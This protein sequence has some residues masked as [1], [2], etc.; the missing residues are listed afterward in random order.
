MSTKNVDAQRRRIIAGNWKMNGNLQTNWDLLDKIAEYRDS[1]EEL[2][3]E[4]SDP[5]ECMS[6]CI[7]FP[8]AVYIHQTS[9][10]LEDSP[11]QW[12]AQNVSQ[13]ADGAY[14]GEISV[15][16][17]KDLKCDY[18][19]IGHSERRTLFGETNEIV[20][21]KFQVV[22]ESGLTPIL[23]VGETLAERESGRAEAVLAE[24]LAVITNWKNSVIAYEPV[25]AIGTGVTATPEQAQAMHVWIRQCV[26]KKDPVIAEKISILYGGSVKASNA[27][28]LFA[29]P[30][31]DGAL[32]GGASLNADEFI[33]ILAAEWIA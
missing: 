1:Q 4:D 8:P 12:G 27:E 6:T 26:A 17:L 5:K 14:T 30:D 32:V 20:G 2:I 13:H 11:V 15:S 18:A 25:W 7:I 19:L 9:D 31:I 10:I 16:M 3:P 28:S 33:A 22:Q 29:M 23:C 24:Q 21:Q